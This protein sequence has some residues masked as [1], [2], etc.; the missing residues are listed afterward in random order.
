M[1]IPSSLP[2]SISGRIEQIEAQFE[3]SNTAFARAY[4]QF[5][6]AKLT[7]TYDSESIYARFPDLN[8]PETLKEL[9]AL[10]K[11]HPDNTQLCRLYV[12]V[13]DMVIGNQLAKASDKLQNE[14][15]KLLI[16]VEGL[17]LKDPKALDGPELESLLYEDTPE[18]LKTLSDKAKRQLLHER[19]NQA[20][21]KA[22]TPL[23]LA[24]Y[25]NEDELLEEWGIT[26]RIEFHTSTSG[27]DLLKLGEVAQTLLK[28]TD[29]LYRPR[30]Q[31]LYESKI[32]GYS[33]QKDAS[34]ADIAYLFYGK[35]EDYLSIDEKFP[36]QQLVPLARKTFEHLGLA[37]DEIADTVDFQAKQDYDQSV[38]NWPEADPRIL[39]DISKR[40]GKR[41][42][43]Y[44]YPAK[45]PSE[46]YLSV[47]P[48]GGLDD[49][50][51]FFHESGHA[52][53][54]AHTAPSLPY[55]LALMG[56]NT[57]TETYAYLTQNLFLN[58]HWLT[59]QAGL[60]QAEAEQLVNRL[61]LN[62]LYMA[63]RYASKL[64]FELQLFEP[65]GQPLE[66]KAPIYE[67][68]LTGG[69]GFRYEP[70]GWARDVDAGFYVADYFTAW[71]LEASLRLYLMNHFGTTTNQGLDWYLNPKAG[72]FL[73]ELW[74]KGN[75]NQHELSEHLGLS[76][77]ADQTAFIQ[78][79]GQN[80]GHL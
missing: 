49:Y 27:H 10:F 7:E 22:I 80:L 37:F 11:E 30:I 69:T 54:F 8:A 26:N 50:S 6:T 52:M 74:A 65:H 29:S 34:R 46:I 12:S 19:I 38:E 79:M 32:K 64:C 2:T 73:K 20:Y 44:V 55:S 18:W 1:A 42:R 75:L 72:E 3:A 9:Q 24:L 62:D 21:T 39:L 78:L 33:F 43:A 67:E 63:R 47:K 76:H 70:E 36:E 77:P 31:S 57:V 66:S 16:D 25:Q 53:H 40:E 28:E 41:S 14:K 45:V 51:A 23:V 71:A 58:R 5:A 56:N 68:L 15:N 61:A 35:E 4:Y 17:G 48:Q 59:K 13:L 60:S